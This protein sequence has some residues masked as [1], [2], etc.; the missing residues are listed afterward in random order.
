MI[1]LSAVFKGE[2]GPYTN[3]ELHDLPSDAARKRALIAFATSKH[4][5]LMSLL[6]KRDYD[7]I[8]LFTASGKTPRG[9]ASGLA[10]KLIAQ[11]YQNVSI[12]DSQ[13]ASLEGIVKQLDESFVHLY[14]ERNCNI[15][16]GLTG[17]KMQAVAAG[18]INSQRKI[19]QAWYI[20]PNE[21][22]YAK[23]TS[24]VGETTVLKISRTPIH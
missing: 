13:S 7:E 6:D 22:D 2:S 9:I 15:E 14:F 23:F 21:F 18:I 11:N 8:Q 10:A 4:E 24:G 19:S 1:A 20:S 3:R 12:F 16:I 5:R 17:N